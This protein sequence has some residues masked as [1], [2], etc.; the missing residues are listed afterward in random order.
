MPLY[1]LQ[2]CALRRYLGDHGVFVLPL[3]ME[4]MP[5]DR[6]A[7]DTAFSMGVLYHRRSPLDHLADL[8]GALVPG[9]QLVLETLIVEGT[10]I[11]VLVPRNRYARMRNVWFIPS[12]EMLYTWLARSGF[13]NITLV[14]I[15]ATTPEEQRRTRWMP[16]ES[17]AE[18]LDPADPGRTVEGYPA[19]LRAILTAN[20][21]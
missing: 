3:R 18:S 14:D 9:G 16:L 17:L 8:R 12:V 15:T 7:F 4:E 21:R 5:R 2:F 6:R 20:A 13:T 19:P 11:T 1:V 10:D